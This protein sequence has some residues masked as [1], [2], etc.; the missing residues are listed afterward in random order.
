MDYR[1]PAHKKMI[2]DFVDDN[3]RTQ[4][5][6]GLV[7]EIDLVD[8]RTGRTMCS[9]DVLG[10]VYN[11]GV[12]TGFDY[13]E[14]KT[15]ADNKA[16]REARKQEQHFYKW[17]RQFPHITPRFYFVSRAGEELWTRQ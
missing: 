10:L 17:A 9:P 7:T 3:S 4:R 8:L 14:M 2:D 11:N 6:H 5:Y 13:F 1:N 16:R 15:G 12:V